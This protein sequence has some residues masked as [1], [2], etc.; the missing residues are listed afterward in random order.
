[1][2][3]VFWYQEQAVDTT[4]EGHTIEKKPFICGIMTP[5]QRSTLA[6]LGHG[7]TVELDCTFG[8][9]KYMVSVVAHKGRQGGDYQVCF[10]GLSHGVWR[11][12]AG[13]PCLLASCAAGGIKQAMTVS[14]CPLCTVAVPPLERGGH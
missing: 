11:G 8:T 12:V 3:Q 10:D 5:W 4:A 13:S 14:P 2:L 6:K 7:A 9:N 1:M